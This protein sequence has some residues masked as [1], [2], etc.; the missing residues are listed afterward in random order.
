MPAVTAAVPF[1]AVHLQIVNGSRQA[2]PP[3][4]VAPQMSPEPLDELWKAHGSPRLDSVRSP[5]PAAW[6]AEFG[7]VGH[8]V[9]GAVERQ[10]HQNGALTQIACLLER[11]ITFMIADF[12][13]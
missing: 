10:L 12:F 5:A 2:T 7:S 9:S 13:F 8:A 4:N 6:A 3:F 1:S 11:Y